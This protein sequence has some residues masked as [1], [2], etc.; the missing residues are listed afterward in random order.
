MSLLDELKGL[1]NITIAPKLKKISINFGSGNK[2]VTLS[3]NKL[4]IDPNLVTPVEKK[5]LYKATSNFVKIEEGI[6]IEE[7]TN[8]MFDGFSKSHKKIGNIKL[9][10]YFKDSNI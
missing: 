6:I 10:K 7:K 9:L 2:S 5:K 8:K 4:N 3:A 1:F